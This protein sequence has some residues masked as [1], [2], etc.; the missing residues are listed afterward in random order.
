M[1][2]VAGSICANGIAVQAS[3]ILIIPSLD[4]AEKWGLAPSSIRH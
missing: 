2:T 3:G 1:V 4:A